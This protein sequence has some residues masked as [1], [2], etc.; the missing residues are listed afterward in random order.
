MEN[1]RG[2]TH[3]DVITGDSGDN[4]INAEAGDDIVDGGVGNDTIFGGAGDDVIYGDT[5]T[6]PLTTLKIEN[7]G[8][9]SAGY[10]N[11]YG[12]YEVG[13]DGNPE[14]GQIIWADVK[15]SVGQTFSLEGVDK[16]KL[17][18]SLSQMEIM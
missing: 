11:S 17:D 1:V 13:E 9:A 4:R 7:M 5:Q 6:Q 16:E 2:S 10:H 14:K 3:D 12:Y 8:K 18:S 15:D